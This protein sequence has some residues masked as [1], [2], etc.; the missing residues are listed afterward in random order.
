MQ[1]RVTKTY[2]V[3]APSRP[4]ALRQ[5]AGDCERR[6]HTVTV[7]AK[8]ATV[9]PPRR[10]PDLVSRGSPVWALGRA[11]LRQMRGGLSVGYAACQPLAAAGGRAPSRQRFGVR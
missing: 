7:A 11:F 2:V 9:A 5:L 1:Y 6:L 10:L 3:E 4:A 8:R